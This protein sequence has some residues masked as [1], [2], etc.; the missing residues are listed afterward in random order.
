MRPPAGC[1]RLGQRLINLKKLRRLP[2][3]R[4][5]PPKSP[6]AP[7]RSHEWRRH[8]GTG[9][10]SR[11]FGVLKSRSGRGLSGST[12]L[13]ADL[14]LPQRV[15]V[16]GAVVVLPRLTRGLIRRAGSGGLT[17]RGRGNEGSQGR[18][19]DELSH[20]TSPSI[21]NFRLSKDMTSSDCYS[22][23]PCSA[24]QAPY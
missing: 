21:V 12:L 11:I 6:C 23:W 10:R 3:T 17:E 24:M 15:S 2:R 4:G 19:G 14:P 8:G 20:D 5:A 1:V 18:T 13:A 7:T 16:P 9:D 22:G